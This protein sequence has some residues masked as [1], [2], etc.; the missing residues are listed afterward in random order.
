MWNKK[1]FEEHSSNFYNTL[2]IMV[3]I[4]VFFHSHK[5]FVK[6]AYF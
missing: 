6:S 1:D 5:D 3:N 2:P 4:K